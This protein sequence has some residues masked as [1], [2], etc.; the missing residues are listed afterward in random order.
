MTRIIFLH[1]DLG[2]GGA[3]RLV[4]DAALALKK[5]GHDVSFVTTH[6]D[7]DHCFLET[8]DG[9]IPVTVVG[10]WLPRHILGKFFAL[11]AYIRMVYAATYIIF[12]R[13]RPDLVFC[14]L[15]SVCIPILRLY[16]PYIVFY[17]HHPDQLLSTPGSYSKT[18]Y[19]VP[20]NYLEEITTG[21]AHKIF[22]NSIYTRNVF[23]STFKKLHVQP[24]VLYPSI[25]TDF[26]DKTR[27]VILERILDR[28]LSDDSII[29]L[30]INRYE[31]KK[32][33]SLA[34]ETLAY[35]KNSLT[36]KEYKRLYLIMAG[37]YDKRV[38]ENVEH[39]LEL[40]E[41]SDELHVTDK[42]IFLR[43]PSDIYK[44]SLL[45]YCDI[46]I[47]TPQNEHFGIVPLEA[48]YIGKPVIAHNSG[49]PME[50][51]IDKVTGYLVNGSSKEFAEKIKILI[52]NP[53][54]IEKYGKA[55]REQ[56]LKTFSFTAFSNQLSKAIDELINCKK[57]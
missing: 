17:C 14:D 35:L 46:L 27:I 55:G 18:L 25:N 20:L 36:E 9:T 31:R 48:M 10:N 43:S 13:N 38:E 22:V 39:Y 1:P 3:E 50:S 15:V 26:F 28:K 19:R 56:F 30:S 32:N 54:L 11:C 16:I 52:K 45:K 2:I 33:L 49:G 40:I 7:P 12:L 34:I 6:H 47:Y 5:N 41:L 44:V 21:M 51:V 29:L 42:V 37:G 23:K 24:E 53:S 57:D 4:V 8:K